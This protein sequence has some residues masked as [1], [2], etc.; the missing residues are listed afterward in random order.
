MDPTLAQ[1]YSAPCFFYGSDTL[2]RQE[3]DGLLSRNWTFA[4]LANELTEHNDFIRVSMFGTDVVIQNFSGRHVAFV[5]S[6]SHRHSQIQ[7]EQRGNRTLTCPY[8]GWTYDERG[9]PVGIPCRKEFPEVCA[10]PERFRLSAVQLASA[11]TFMFIRSTDDGPDLRTFLGERFNFLEMVSESLDRSLEVRESRVQA[12]WKIVIENSLEG[13]H[14]PLVHRSTLGAIAQLSRE[15]ESVVNHLPLTG[16]SYM[17][18]AAS[19][20]WMKR[21]TAYSNDVGR[22]PFSFDHY[23]HQLIFPLLTITS[24]LGY[25]FHI[26]QF[27]PEAVD[28]TVVRS[29]IYAARFSDQT[30]RGAKMMEAIFREN[31]EFTRQIFD[32]D[33]V[34]CERAH[35]GSLQARR[36]GVLAHRLEQRVAAFRA[37]YLSG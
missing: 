25:S 2:F 10:S 37:T 18:N 15:D 27:Y 17:H 5:N 34:A 26:Q 24:F 29:W 35:A 12:N 36:F 30:Q 7:Y 33:R 9:I 31:V 14:V 23:V 21:W 3:C 11:G 28:S 22:W 1:A 6:C 20:E 32:E 4:G 8:H 13:Y 19:A 16:H